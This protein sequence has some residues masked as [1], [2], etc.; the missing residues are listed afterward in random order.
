MG[1]CLKGLTCA[2]TWMVIIKDKSKK[3][4]FLIFF[5]TVHLKYSF[6]NDG[7]GRVFQ[8]SFIAFSFHPR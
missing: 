4:D 5:M 7:P 2:E 1:A 8:L 3:F 6:E